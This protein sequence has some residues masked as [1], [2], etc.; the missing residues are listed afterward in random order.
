MFGGVIGLEEVIAISLVLACA[1]N[2]Y[3]SFVALD[4]ETKPTTP[5]Q[6]KE[7]KKILFICE[8]KPG[9][10]RL[11]KKKNPYRRGFWKSSDGDHQSLD[12]HLENYQ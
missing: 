3:V 7:K 6:K 8:R 2:V 1:Y 4:G 5:Q 11:K 10:Q 12:T 9:R